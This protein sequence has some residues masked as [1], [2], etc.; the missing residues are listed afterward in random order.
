MELEIIFAEFG[1]SRQNNNNLKFSEMGRLDPT[2]SSA[3][4]Y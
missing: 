1:K 4:Q 3:K 2:Y